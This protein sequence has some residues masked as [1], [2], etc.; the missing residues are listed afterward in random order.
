METLV[1]EDFR[2]IEYSDLG[3]K[4][5]GM[6]EPTVDKSRKEFSFERVPFIIIQPVLIDLKNGV[7][8][9]FIKGHRI[10]HAH[11]GKHCT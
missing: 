11:E 9:R 8:K 3:D 2:F 6:S 1:L 10:Y 7:G 4:V 5:I